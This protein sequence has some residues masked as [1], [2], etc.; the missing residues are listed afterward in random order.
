MDRIRQLIK[1]EIKDVDKKIQA[2]ASQ[3]GYENLD[4]ISQE[5]AELIADEVQ[6]SDG[7]GL[8]VQE[9]APAPIAKG[10][11]G[12]AAQH[13]NPQVQINPSMKDVVL[14]LVKGTERLYETTDKFCGQLTA[15]KSRQIVERLRQVNPDI[16]ASVVSE[17]EI[18]AQST[19]KFCTELESML[20]EAYSSF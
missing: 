18:E 3:L 12:K 9:S 1:G 6:K 19:E 4:S 15:D 13:V 14:D 2:I 16:L 17:L 20:R 10:K 5:E 8:M 11:K 7:G